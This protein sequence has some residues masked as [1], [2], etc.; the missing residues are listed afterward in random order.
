MSLQPKTYLI[1]QDYLAWERQ[2]ETR[3]EWSYTTRQPDCFRRGRRT[4]SRMN[5]AMLME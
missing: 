5:S 2:Q 3:Q 4:L 1:A